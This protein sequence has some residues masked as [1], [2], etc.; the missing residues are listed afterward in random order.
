MTL[1]EIESRSTFSQCLLTMVLKWILL[2]FSSDFLRVPS[3]CVFFSIFSQVLA[4]SYCKRKV[5]WV[6]TISN[7]CKMVRVPGAY[8][9]IRKHNFRVESTLFMPLW[10]KPH[11]KICIKYRKHWKSYVSFQLSGQIGLIWA[12]LKLFSKLTAISPAKDNFL[13]QFSSRYPR[14]K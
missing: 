4:T 12:V 3:F 2:P 6:L 9:F 14:S 5:F 13:Y 11:P 8:L 10:L 1:V 7:I